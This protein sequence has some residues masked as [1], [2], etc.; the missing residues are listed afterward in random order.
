MS[1]SKEKASEIIAAIKNKESLDNIKSRLS[2]SSLEWNNISSSAYNQSLEIEK[3]RRK[4]EQNR[5]YVSLTSQDQINEILGVNSE[6]SK[7]AL[8]VPILATSSDL[9]V[10]KKLIENLPTTENS[11][12]NLVGKT[13]MHPKFRVQQKKGRFEIFEPFSS[14]IQIIDA[15]TISYYRT[16]FVSCFLT[17]TPLIEGIIIRW[18]GYKP[19]DEKPEFEDIRK[20]FKNSHTRQPCPGNILFHDI[21]VKVCDKILNNH[22]YRPTTTGSSHS[23]FNRHVASHLLNDSEFATREN[24]IRLFLLLDTMSE[25]YVYEKRVCDPRFNLNLNDIKD[26]IDLLVNTMFNYSDESAEHQLLGSK[27]EDLL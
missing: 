26:E 13:T 12:L 24:C 21:Y 4:L 14:F 3:K 22:L 9:T 25:I 18:M 20:F 1:K 15:A 2:S 16:N 11:I 6:I 8:L 27:L 10:I 7:F 5:P 19:G 17:L 23:N